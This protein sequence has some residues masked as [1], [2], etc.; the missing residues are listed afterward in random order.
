MN[1]RPYILYIIGL[2]MFVASCA[3]QDETV[4]YSE[5]EE[6]V[7]DSESESSEENAKILKENK[8]I[9][10]TDIL[11]SKHYWKVGR[12]KVEDVIDLITMLSDS[13]LDPSIKM[14]I[15]SEVG[16][17]MLVSLDDAES[18]MAHL[19]EVKKIK[20]TRD[21]TELSVC[22]SGLRCFS[23]IFEL[24]RKGGGKDD[25]QIDFVLVE[26]TQDFGSES[27]IVRKVKIENV[28]MNSS[29]N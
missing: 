15:E 11:A 9:A 2:L 1:A 6:R 28:L 29:S 22:E 7:E 3:Q 23:M 14:V 8:P 17:L 12:Q 5:V 18:I 10:S 4:Q 27:E 16:N 20:S 26:E 13:T 21:R 24:K 25:V 19:K